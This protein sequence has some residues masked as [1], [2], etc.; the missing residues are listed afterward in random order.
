L[1]SIYAE[2]WVEKN[3]QKGIIIGKGGEMIR[4]IGTLARRDIEDLLGSKIY[5]ELVVKVKENWREKPAVLDT[6]GIRA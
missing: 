6:L 3:T 2:I 5:L 4:K 1:I